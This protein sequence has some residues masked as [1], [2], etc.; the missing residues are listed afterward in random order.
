[1]RALVALMAATG[2]TLLVSWFWKEQLKGR[3]E[4]MPPLV[5]QLEKLVEAGVLGGSPEQLVA[6]LVFSEPFQEADPWDTAPKRRGGMASMFGEPRELAFLGALSREPRTAAWR[7]GS[8]GAED[9]AAAEAQASAALAWAAEKGVRLRI[10]SHG[11]AMLPVLRAALAAP[12]TEPPVVERLLGVGLS[13]GDIRPRDP[14]LAEALTKRPPAAE[15]LNL[16]SDPSAVPRV[17]MLE[18]VG[19]GPTAQA[20]ELAWPG[21][22]WV[23]LVVEIAARGRPQ[24]PQALPAATGQALLSARQFRS[25]KD[26]KVTTKVVDGKGRAVTGSLIVPK[27]DKEEIPPDPEAGEKKEGS[28]PAGHFPVL[29]GGR[30]PRI[31]LLS[32]GQD[33][34]WTVIRRAFFNS[35]LADRIDCGTHQPVVV[36]LGFQIA[37]V[38]TRHE[39]QRN[40]QLSCGGPNK[41]TPVKHHGYPA[42]VC[43]GIA[44]GLGD[45]TIDLLDTF[46]VVDEDLRLE[47]TY[48]YPRK[49]RRG[50]YLDR[51]MGTIEGLEPKVKR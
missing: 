10:V 43:V 19:P 40:T 1:M 23:A 29:A 11:G 45:K 22:S 50:E 20:E 33:S 34:G 48:M 38:C 14:D 37:V 21:T 46:I 26:G 12:A 35:R 4:P 24:R 25:V 51:F 36:G 42:S 31:V 30:E 47:V 17:L 15:W 9:R 8:L 44:P 41:A 13:L 3:V 49:E 39:T 32:K 18:T 2:L 7:L 5:A 27:L 6:T 28:G 16:Y